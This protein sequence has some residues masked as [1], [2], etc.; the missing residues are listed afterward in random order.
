MT[1]FDAF[2][3]LNFFWKDDL[4]PSLEAWI[5]EK[6]ALVVPCGVNNTK[7][8]LIAKLSIYGGSN[9]TLTCVHY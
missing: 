3:F 8:I 5:L 4:T 9:I 7:E 6:L 1:S 2:F